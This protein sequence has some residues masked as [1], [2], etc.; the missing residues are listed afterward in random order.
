MPALLK[1]QPSGI[2]PAPWATAL[3]AVLG[4]P[5]D[6]AQELGPLWRVVVYC[7]T[8]FA[9]CATSAMVQVSYAKLERRIEAERDRIVVLKADLE[10]LRA[11]E[12]FRRGGL[13]QGH[14]R[15]QLELGGGQTLTVPASPDLPGEGR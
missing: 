12:S 4:V 9:V 2:R 13:Y 11:E 15:Q 1:Q 7:V 10:R 14:L 6:R 3:G 8:L 5:A